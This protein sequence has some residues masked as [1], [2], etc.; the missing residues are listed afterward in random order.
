LLHV[1]EGPISG[2][3]NIS[4]HLQ[5]EVSLIRRDPWLCRLS[6]ENPLRSR[7]CPENDLGQHLE[8]QAVHEAAQIQASDSTGRGE[9]SHVYGACGCDVVL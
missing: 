5:L 6:G 3:Q 9:K 8:A 2:P 7:F 4:S 1:R